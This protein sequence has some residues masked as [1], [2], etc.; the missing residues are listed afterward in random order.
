MMN[1]QPRPPTESL[2]R[3]I[4]R[5]AALAYIPPRPGVK[6]ADTK[7]FANLADDA[8]TG[9]A[10]LLLSTDQADKALR[11]IEGAATAMLEKAGLARKLIEA[12]R[13]SA[14]K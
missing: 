11:Q 13:D 7:T 3:E 10:A 1:E 5:E 4:A 12:V 8:A 2:E 14:Q 9:I 6:E